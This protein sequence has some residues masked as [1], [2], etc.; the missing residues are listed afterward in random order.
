MHLKVIALKESNTG[1]VRSKINFLA[2]PQ[3]E[4]DSACHQPNMDVL[5]FTDS[6]NNNKKNPEQN[7]FSKDHFK[8]L[9]AWQLKLNPVQH[10]SPA[11]QCITKRRGKGR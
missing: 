8:R 4:G 5:V 7:A 10:L 1:D 9:K 2:G 3:L 11:Y 6:F